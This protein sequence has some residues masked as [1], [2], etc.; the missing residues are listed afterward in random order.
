MTSYTPRDITK[1]PRRPVASDNSSDFP[2]VE[3]RGIQVV[4]F[5]YTYWRDEGARTHHRRS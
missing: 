4:E 2:L 3:A 5:P 1:S